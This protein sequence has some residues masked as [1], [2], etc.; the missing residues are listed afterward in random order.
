MGKPRAP[1]V[2]V[3]DNSFPFSKFIR[4]MFARRGFAVFCAPSPTQGLTVF[5]ANW[6]RID[7]VVVDLVRPAAANLDLTAELE[8]LRPGLSVLYLVSERKTIAS[9]SIQAKAPDSVLIAP[10]TAQLL[11]ARVD[12]L[13]DAIPVLPPARRLIAGFR[14]GL[15]I[16]F[17]VIRPEFAR[18]GGN[19]ARFLATFRAGRNETYEYSKD[20]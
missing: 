19:R 8:R 12:R 13:L 9:C 10:F 20:T 2:L 14:E 15:R 7:L 6:R 11:V 1:G 18:F 4:P 17:T 16:A 5:G 3:I